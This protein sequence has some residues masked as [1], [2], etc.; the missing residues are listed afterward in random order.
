MKRELTCIVCP[1]GC[2][3]TVEKCGEGLKVTGNG[4]PKGND[5]AINECLHPVRTVTLALR[6][7]NREDCMVS[8]RTEH[9]VAKESMFE[10]VAELR[11]MTV[12]APLHVGDV[13]HENVCGSRIVVTKSI[14]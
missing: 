12:N 13:L 3:L 1:R 5:Y 2:S 4:C 6:V 7:A 11:K 8:V 14:L 9:P 10:V